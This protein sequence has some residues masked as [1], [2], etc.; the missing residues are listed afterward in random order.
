MPDFHLRPASPDDAADIAAMFN[1]PRVIDGTLRL[2]FTP[3]MGI[4]DWIAGCDTDRRMVIAEADG[5]AVGFV[6]L[7]RSD[8]RMAHCGELYL[9]VHDAFHRIGIGAALMKAAMDIADNWMGLVRLELET[10]VTNTGAIRLYEACGFQIE[11]RGRAG[12]L[13]NGEYVDHFFMARIRPAPLR[14]PED[15]AEAP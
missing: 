12:T 6:Q 10:M 1:Q 13:V 8:G 5:R 14:R 7:R 9:A 11:G 3:Q 4:A 2:P 15:A